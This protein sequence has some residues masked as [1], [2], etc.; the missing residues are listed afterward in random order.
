MIEE[1]PKVGDLLLLDWGFGR[2][3]M[4]V[5]RRILSID[6]VYLDP[7]GCWES[8]LGLNRRK[9]EVIGK[10]T[11]IFGPFGYKTYYRESE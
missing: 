2:R 4:W 10:Y 3:E 1:L 9:V 5:S 7:A 6:S 8:K 11:K